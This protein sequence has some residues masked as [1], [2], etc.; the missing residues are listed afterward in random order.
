MTLS[1]KFQVGVGSAR[2]QFEGRITFRGTAN[3]GTRISFGSPLR[4]PLTASTAAASAPRV[5]VDAAR[6]LLPGV[7]DE[8]LNSPPATLK[9]IRRHVSSRSAAAAWRCRVAMADRALDR[10]QS[11]ASTL[12]ASASNCSLRRGMSDFYSLRMR[13]FR[14]KKWKYT[15]NTRTH[16]HTAY[17]RIHV[18][19]LAHQCRS[20]YTRAVTRSTYTRRYS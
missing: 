19:N 12:C 4:T 20:L 17:W 7:A 18:C 3:H 1:R 8:M 15:E 14:S 6:R 13:D 2:N 10:A 11:C 16:T 9:T 5:G